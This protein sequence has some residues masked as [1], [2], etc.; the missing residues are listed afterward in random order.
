[1]RGLLLVNLGT[2]DAP[3]SS[4]VRRYLREFLSDPRVIDINPVGRA[5]LLNLIILPFRSAK[6]AK[7][8]QSIWTKQGS[9]LLLHSQGLHERVTAKM[10]EGW[11]VELAMRYGSPN[12]P[13]ALDRLQGA[14]CEE[15]V[16]L[17]LYPQAAS[18]STGS[19]VER[20]YDEAKKRWIVPYIQVV[21]AFYDEPEFIE[22]FAD[23]GRPLLE[24]KKPDHVIF[25]FHGLP[26][27]HLHKSDPRGDTC[28]VS[29]TCCSSIT[30]N[31]TGCYRAQSFAT[32][33]GIAASLGLADEMWSVSFQSRLG[34]TPW[35]KPYFDDALPK[36]AKA[37][38]KNLLVFS[39]A[40]V[41][42]CLE[43]LEEISL[44][45]SEQWNECGGEELTL[46]PSLNATDRWVDLVVDLAKRN[47][48]LAS[49]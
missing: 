37:G 41:A 13:D 30:E 22:A 8:Y 6:S 44:R 20:V 19:T 1:M 42:D 9:P 48:R 33:R 2:P 10:G 26:E 3:T 25:S 34:R 21:P 40:F 45:A 11:Q 5:F 39:P 4:A 36:L 24:E 12:I 29:E 32:A 35:I 46:V 16:V 14:G 28:L 43:T 27:R 38:A 7:L 31:N 47:A 18:S 49:R 15:I 17:A 23:Q